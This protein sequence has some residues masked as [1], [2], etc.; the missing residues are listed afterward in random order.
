MQRK[1]EFLRWQG[2]RLI[3]TSV[4]NLSG[5]GTDNVRDNFENML[6]RKLE[7][8]GIECK[9]LSDKE[10][11]DRVVKKQTSRMVRMFVQFIQKSKKKRWSSADVK[12]QVDKHTPL[13]Q[14]EEEFLKLAIRVYKEYE[15]KIEEQGKIDFDML[16]EKSVGLIET[17]QGNCSISLGHNRD[18][19]IRMSELEWILID[20]YQDFSRQFQGLVNAIRQNNKELKL[21][22]VGDDWQ[23]INGFAG[24][25]ISYFDNFEENYLAAGR[26]NLLTNYR[27][28]K[29]IVEAG[30]KL[31][32]GCGQE[33]KF[34]PNRNE[35]LLEVLDITS[36]WIEC[37][38]NNEQEY[39]KDLKYR[40]YEELEDGRQRS[41]DN[42]EL[43]AKYVKTMFEV[44]TEPSN[45]GKEI[46]ILSRTN[47]FYYLKDV[48][49][50]K[51][52][53]KF[54]FAHDNLLEKIGGPEGFD[55]LFKIGTVHSF[56]GLQADI[57]F[58]LKACDGTFPLIHPD[59]A[60]YRIFGESEKTILDEEKRLF[61]V[62]LT[63]AKQKVYLLTE[64]DDKSPFLSEI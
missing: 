3:E 33:A 12:A 25:D 40:F 9:R 62:A 16:M 17:T 61:Y 45:L 36:K 41:S 50:I 53:L 5:N 42:G 56:K 38:K 55:K 54:C 1:K 15:H 64:A 10:I 59:W 8:C 20:E 29:A 2:I 21:F 26:K 39:R 34:L 14:R 46:A 57:V 60:L 32:R 30:N 19:Q 49:T 27:C 43:Q 35:G 37:D 47:N 31:M 7:D 51:Q 23:A 18:R 24:S 22:C 13:D 11:A 28:D 63:R 4:A 52:K 6:K 48:K 58:I 44:A